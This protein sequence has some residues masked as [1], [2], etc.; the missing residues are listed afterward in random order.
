MALRSTRL[1][2]AIRLP[3]FLKQQLA[4]ETL[5][6]WAPLSFQVG[7]SAQVPEL[8][9]HSYVLLFPRSFGSF[10]RWYGHVKPSAKS[11]LH[12]FR[13]Q[14]ERKLREDDLMPLLVDKVV[15][16]SRLKTPS[17]AFK[18]MVKVRYDRIRTKLTSHATFQTCIN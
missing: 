13:R 14:L 9:V 5:Q 11:M 7:L 8:E 15:I 1:Q 10:I 16:Q 18:K 3:A 6:L 2:H 4:I 12:K 17:S